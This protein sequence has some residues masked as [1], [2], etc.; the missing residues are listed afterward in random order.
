MRIL[1]VEDEV[2]LAKSLQEILEDSGHT[3]S[4]AYDGQ[5]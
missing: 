1:I 5:E 4:S 2:L 3:V